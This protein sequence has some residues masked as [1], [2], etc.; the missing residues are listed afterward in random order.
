MEASIA[1]NPDDECQDFFFGYIF[2]Q[3]R[4]EKVVVTEQR[5]LGA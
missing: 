2:N 4:S 3:L 1:H 5:A